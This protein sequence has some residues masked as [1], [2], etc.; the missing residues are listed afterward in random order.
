MVGHLHIVT[1][2]EKPLLTIVTGCNWRFAL[3]FSIDRY[4]FCIDLGPLWISIEW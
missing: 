1:S 2:K 3:G 4:S